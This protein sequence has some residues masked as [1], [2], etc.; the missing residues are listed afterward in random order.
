LEWSSESIEIKYPHPYFKTAQGTPQ[1][2][3]YYPDFFIKVKDSHG[4][5]RKYV[6]EV[7][8]E[9]ETV[10]PDGPRRGKSRKTILEE[11]KRWDINK[12]KWKAAMN[13]CNK[14]GYYFKILTEKQL[15]RGS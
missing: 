15:F 11:R 4:N 12:A 3:R 5:V 14:M 10:P 13:V 1:F 7:K 6:I 2:R 9:K 8:P